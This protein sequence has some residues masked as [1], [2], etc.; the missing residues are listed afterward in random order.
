MQSL[1][2][3]MT[4]REHMTLTSRL[5]GALVVRSVILA[6]AISIVTLLLAALFFPPA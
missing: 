1:P 3:I 6:A 2:A 5:M 4:A